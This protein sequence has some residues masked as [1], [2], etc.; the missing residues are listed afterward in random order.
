MGSDGPACEAVVDNQA[1][2]FTWRTT[3]IE[4]YRPRRLGGHDGE[5]RCCMNTRC[6]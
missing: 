3:D 6:G 2:S 5:G 1:G 4:R